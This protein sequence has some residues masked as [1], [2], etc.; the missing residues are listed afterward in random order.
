MSKIAWR[1]AHKERNTYT[2]TNFKQIRD[3]IK[4][5]RALVRRTFFFQHNDTKINDFDEGV[6]ILE[7]FF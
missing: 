6:L 2:I 7:P 1:L 3:K 5:V 4:L